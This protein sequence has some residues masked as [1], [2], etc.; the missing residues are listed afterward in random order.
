VTGTWSVVSGHDLAGAL[1]RVEGSG[2]IAW[3]A[4]LRPSAR[5]VSHALRAA[6]SAP[7]RAVHWFLH[8]RSTVIAEAAHAPGQS[9]I[10]VGRVPHA[11]AAAIGAVPT[12][13][14]GLLLLGTWATSAACARLADLAGP[15]Q[16]ASATAVVT[17][18]VLPAECTPLPARLVTDLRADLLERALITDLAAALARAQM[19]REC[20]VSGHSAQM[21]GGRSGGKGSGGESLSG[22]A[23]SGRTRA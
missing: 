1:T 4:V 7:V 11:A 20:D 23:S 18:W 8:P 3:P 21:N 9:V 6:V 22:A 14:P 10:L 16:D 15:A 12:V 2:P 5:L 19:S 13:D 17:R